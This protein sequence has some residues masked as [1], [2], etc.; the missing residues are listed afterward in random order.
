MFET[1]NQM[2]M[3]ALKVYRFERSWVLGLS[4]LGFFF[5]THLQMVGKRCLFLKLRPTMV[6]KVIF[7]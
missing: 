5:P 2:K 4:I 3:A 1:T 7:L 6:D